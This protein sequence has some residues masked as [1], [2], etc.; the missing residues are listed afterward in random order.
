MRWLLSR[1][2]ELIVC[3]LVMAGVF[4][5]PRLI[6]WWAGMPSADERLL[7]AI[8]SDDVELRDESLRSG[9]SVNATDPQ[10]QTAVILSARFG[11]M[12]CARMLLDAGA[13]VR[14]AD[15]TGQTALHY[16]MRGG[17]DEIARLLISHGADTTARDH[18]RRTPFEMPAEGG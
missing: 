6:D 2:F 3:A 12:R 17:R 4:A 5:T 13:D 18:H 11:W 7:V 8:T 10:G 9:A 15:Y 14:C 16:A 1:T